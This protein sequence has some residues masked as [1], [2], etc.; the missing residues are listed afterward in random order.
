[1]PAVQNTMKKQKVNAMK[2]MK[3]AMKSKKSPDDDTKKSSDGQGGNNMKR[4]ASAPSKSTISDAV[5][6]MQRGVGEESDHE[7][8]EKRDKEK[9]KAMRSQFPSHILTF[10]TRQPIPKAHLVRFARNW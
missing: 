5:K 9:F 8:S 2:V 4:P 7:E 10:T 3:Q 6:E 1:M